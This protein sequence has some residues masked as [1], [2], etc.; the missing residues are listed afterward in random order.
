M[1]TGLGHHRT[2]DN[3][4]ML[5]YFFDITADGR[6]AS[7][8]AGVDVSTLAYAECEAVSAVAEMMVSDEPEGCLRSVQ[9]TIRDEDHTWLSRVTITVERR[10]S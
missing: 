4:V 8:E 5:R 7:D 6:N 10:C 3:G 9:L 1:Q 2:E